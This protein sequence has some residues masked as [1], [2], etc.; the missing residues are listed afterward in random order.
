MFPGDRGDVQS[1][2]FTVQSDHEAVEQ[3]RLDP[4][5]LVKVEH[6]GCEY[7]VTKL[8]FESPRLFVKKYSDALAYESAV[9]LLRQLKAARPELA[10]DLDLANR[11]L[12]EEAGKKAGSQAE[13]RAC[14]RGR[15]RSAAAGSP[16]DQRRRSRQ[17][18]RLPRTEVF[19]RAALKPVKRDIS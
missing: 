5:T 18:L 13:A 10:F 9:S 17:V 11:T 16:P 12:M 6:G 1:H 19:Q 14:C 7:V 2:R 4:A 3:F 8:R 15:W